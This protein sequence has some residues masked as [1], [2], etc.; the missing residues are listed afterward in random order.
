VRRGELVDTGDWLGSIGNTGA[1][2]GEHLHLTVVRNTN[3]SFRKSFE[4]NF[5]GGQHDRDGSVG[6]V[7]PFGW[8]PANGLN[9]VDPWA[10]RFR[11]HA[12]NPLLDNAG[13][14]SSRMWLPGEAPPL[15]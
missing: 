4:V 13:G 8:S 10:W 7:D 9:G 6:A 1:S 5:V 15:N 2:Y 3:L 14:F 11:N 12:N